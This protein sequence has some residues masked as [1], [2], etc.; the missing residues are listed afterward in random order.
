M[1]PSS[2]EAPVSSIE[3]QPFGES[4]TT[5]SEE[6]YQFTGK[7]KDASG[8]YYFGARYYDPQVGRFTTKDP[9]PGRIQSP[10]TLNRYVYCLNNPLK[11]LDP[12][13]MQTEPVELPDGTISQPLTDLY[14]ALETALANLSTDQL[15]KINKLLAGSD[16]DKLQAVMMILEAAG[17]AFD[18]NEAT[19]TL[20]IEFNKIKFFIEFANIREHG[21]ITTGTAT[22]NK[23]IVLNNN[24][25][26]AGD[27][28]LT[29][30]HELVHASMVAFHG[31]VLDTIKQQYGDVGNEAFNELIAYQWEAGIA[32]KMWADKDTLR[33]YA[34]KEYIG[35]ILYNLN[36]YQNLWSYIDSGGI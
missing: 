4:S 31:D 14:S 22:G 21:K 34:T 3:Y 29:L 10:Q 30:G 9:L 23:F 1:Y 25:S 15:D 19:N 16:A 28:F 27:L 17:I 11:Y 5:G 12:Q 20:S 35:G 32:E 13:G 6:D 18:F 2:H 7:E 26:K 24:I 33:K 8:L 36:K